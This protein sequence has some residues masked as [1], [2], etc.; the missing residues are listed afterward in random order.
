MEIVLVTCFEIF[1]S[2]SH[3]LLEIARLV[4]DQF[5]FFLELLQYAEVE[6]KGIRGEGTTSR[7]TPAIHMKELFE[8]EEHSFP[9][10]NTV[11]IE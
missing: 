4:L 7:T 10:I 3:D 9:N 2:S 11:K 1:F 6:S 5:N 8:K